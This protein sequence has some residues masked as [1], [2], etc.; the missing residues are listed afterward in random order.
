M[1]WRVLRLLL[2]MTAAGP[3]VTGLELNPVIARPDGVFALDARIK[4]T[5][6]EPQDP[7]LRRLR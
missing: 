5:P 4:V 2:V 3:E 6:C 7:F 1:R